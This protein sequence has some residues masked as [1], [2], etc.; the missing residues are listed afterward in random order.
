[1]GG[2]SR[3]SYGAPRALPSLS[4]AP[5]REL[6]QLL[7][8]LWSLILLYVSLFPTTTTTITALHRVL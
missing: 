7:P 4:L 5:L 2:I 8:H 6:M 1:M 3:P